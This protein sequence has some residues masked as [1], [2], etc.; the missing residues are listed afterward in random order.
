MRRAL[1]LVVVGLA[2][3]G[4]GSAPR[5]KQRR[6]GG[7]ITALRAGARPIG[8]GPRFQPPV[9]GPVLGAC[10]SPLGRRLEA[11]IEVFGDDLVVLLPTGIGTRGPRRVSDGRITRATC[12]GEL[13]TLDPTGTVYFRPGSRL[14]LGAI[15]HTWGQSLTGRRVA[16]FGGSAVRVY[17]D[18][19]IWRG[20]VR[21]V[22]LLPGAEIVLEV[23]PYVPPHTHFSFP[24]LP[25]SGLR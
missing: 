20:S 16:S 11:H 2:V 4:C 6:A 25:P 12:F 10:R 8:R 17:L 22:P 15:F 21:D 7:G 9:R 19:R 24:A 13:V 5:A 1:L 3:A 14:T 18:G 23:G